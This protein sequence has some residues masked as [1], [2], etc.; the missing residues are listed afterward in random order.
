MSYLY[1][2]QSVNTKF[3]VISRPEDKAGQEVDTK[4][5]KDSIPEDSVR[6][7]L[8]SGTLAFSSSSNVTNSFLVR[9]YSLAVLL[10]MKVLVLSRSLEPIRIAYIFRL[11]SVWILH[12]PTTMRAHYQRRA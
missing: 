3:F 12:P 4:N 8:S 10:G 5:G 7:Q 6:A 9:C 2:F 1:K 11:R